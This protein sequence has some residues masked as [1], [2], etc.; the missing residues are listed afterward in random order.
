MNTNVASL[1]K[2]MND[3]RRYYD[4]KSTLNCHHSIIIIDIF[5]TCVR[6]DMVFLLRYKVIFKGYFTKREEE[7]EMDVVDTSTTLKR[8]MEVDL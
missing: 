7:S 4:K 8:F 6:K 2:K 1:L 5:G 3:L